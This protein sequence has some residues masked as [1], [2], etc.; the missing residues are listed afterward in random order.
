MK[1]SSS[2]WAFIKKIIEKCLDASRG[3][4]IK[5]NM[6]EKGIFILKKII[7]IKV[8]FINTT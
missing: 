6:K 4:S 8:I 2:K 1:I 3:N 5:L 7:F